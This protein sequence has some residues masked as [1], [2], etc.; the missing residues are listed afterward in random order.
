[1]IMRFFNVTPFTF[2]G[3]PRMGYSLLM[4]TFLFRLAR[5][6]QM[7]LELMAP[8]DAEARPNQGTARFECTQPR[9]RIRYFFQIDWAFLM[10]KGIIAAAMA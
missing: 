2:K 5:W 9:K 7:H 3:E 8:T 1:M 10:V 4:Q 6:L